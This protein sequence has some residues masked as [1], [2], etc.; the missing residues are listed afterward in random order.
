MGLWDVVVPVVSVV[1]TAGTAV[2][3]KIIDARSKREDRANA[4]AIDYE[5][6]VWQAK[7]DVLR[8]LISAC[9]EV[10]LRAVTYQTQPDP[11]DLE[12]NIVQLAQ[13]MG[14]FENAVGGEEG[15]SE[16]TAYS[17][18][19]VRYAVDEMLAR[20]AEDLA[21]VAVPLLVYRNAELQ[22]KMLKQQP[23]YSLGSAEP[24]KA[25]RDEERSALCERRDK[26]MDEI[27]AKVKIDADSVVDLCD[28]II[29]VA[30][31]DLQGRF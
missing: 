8:R 2:W 25:K 7:N 9:R 14:T 16:I 23:K 27:G 26:S 20:F 12:Y 6:R 22:L 3:S 30:R 11:D 4:R 31:Q 18:E 5:G 17:A 10:K 28:R 15:I 13:A 21:P 1:V 29:D 19:P 24:G